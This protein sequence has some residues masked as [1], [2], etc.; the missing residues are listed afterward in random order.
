MA[1]KILIVDDSLI[2]IRKINEIFIRN[3]YEVVATARNGLEAIKL[4]KEYIPDIVTMD[5]TMPGMNGIDATKEIIEYDSKA[6][7]MMITSHGQEGMVLDAIKAGAKGYLTKPFD[8]KKMIV[9]INEIIQ[10]YGEEK[11]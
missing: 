9:T 4:Y 10:K 5:I 1:L 11:A 3:G 8:S 2:V 6:L 7:I